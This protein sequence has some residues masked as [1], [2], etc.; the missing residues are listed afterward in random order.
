[1]RT[2]QFIMLGIGLIVGIGLA[3][4]ATSFMSNRNNTQN[5]ITSDKAKTI[6]MN[7]VP[8]ATLNELLYDNSDE[9]PSYEAK[10]TKGDY[11]YEIDIDA[12][13]GDILKFKEVKKITEDNQLHLIILKLIQH[14][15]LLKIL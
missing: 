5:L 4:F 1:M 14:L 10:L 6:V 8:G 13:T 15:T 12:K 9:I 2:K 3:L 11:E 7:K